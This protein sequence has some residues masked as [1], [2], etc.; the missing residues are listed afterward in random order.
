MLM[1]QGVLKYI[2]EIT[3]DGCGSCP[4]SNCTSVNNSK[5]AARWVTG[6]IPD[7]A[8]FLPVRIETPSRKLGNSH[9]KKCSGYALSFFES[10]EH[11]RRCLQYMAANSPKFEMKWTYIAHTLINPGDGLVS[12]ADHKGHFDLHEF[13]HVRMEAQVQLVEKV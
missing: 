9:E 11:A 13:D 1:A 4:P 10:A 12:I 8:H 7:P 2:K 6:T 5:I 3:S